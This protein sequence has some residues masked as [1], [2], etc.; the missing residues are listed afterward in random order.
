MRSAVFGRRSR[1][2]E[3]ACGR[4]PR[5]SEST[6]NM[7]LATG[8]KLT[9]TVD[10]TLNNWYRVPVR[11]C[12]NACVGLCSV[13]GVLPIWSTLAVLT[14]RFAINLNH[15]THD[16]ILTAKHKI[17]RKT[18]THREQETV[19]MVMTAEISRR[20]WQYCTLSVPWLCQVHIVKVGKAQTMALTSK[21]LNNKRMFKNTQSSSDKIMFITIIWAVTH[22]GSHN[23]M[24]DRQ[25]DHANGGWIMF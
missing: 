24:T 11:L 20:Q 12:G 3:C 4:G 7:I 1:S 16:F 9:Q 19:L 5:E 23:L 22:S 14:N 17:N 8:A 13:A 21:K 10:S 15:F 6:V 2:L 18:H 25:T